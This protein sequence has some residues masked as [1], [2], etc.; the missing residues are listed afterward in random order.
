M[1]PIDSGGFPGIN[2]NEESVMSLNTLL[3]FKTR[4]Q[5]AVC[6]LFFIAILVGCSSTMHNTG[7]QATTDDLEDRWGIIPVAIR[8]VGGDHFI[9]F[10]YRV[11]DPDKALTLLSR[12][13]QPYL[14]D[15]ASGKVH[16]VPVTKLGPMRSSAIKP[17][18]DRNYVVLFGN[19]HK[20]IQ[21]GSRVTVVIGDF[22][23]EHLTVM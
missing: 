11:T 21:K 15:E 22:R 6:F 12:N 16:T 1:V 2:G 20:L 18:A 8:L 23:A 5:L 19:P 7:M 3:K 17:K 9:D 14:I 10:R 4:R 13:N